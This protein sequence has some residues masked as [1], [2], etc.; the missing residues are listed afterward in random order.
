MDLYVLF[1][2]TG[3]Y[4]ISNNKQNKESVCPNFLSRSERYWRKKDE[5]REAKLWLRMSEVN[6]VAHPGD[7]ASGETCSI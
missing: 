2:P 5:V 6:W 7:V 3:Q 4:I 1:E